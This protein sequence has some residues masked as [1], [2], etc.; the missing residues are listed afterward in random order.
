MRDALSRAR[1]AI[2]HEKARWLARVADSRACAQNAGM[3]ATRDGDT[4]TLNGRYWSA[5]Y[6]IEE[7]PR[8]LAFYRDQREKFPR[9]GRSYDATIRAL[10]DLEE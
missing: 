6:P 10:E 9:S 3:K 1:W 8:W 7:L 5:T 2:P 4:F